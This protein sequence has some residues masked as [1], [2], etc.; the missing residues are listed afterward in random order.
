M[1]GVTAPE[2]YVLDPED[3]SKDLTFQQELYVL[4]YM[5]NGGKGGKAAEAAGYGSPA[6]A[7]S[8]LLSYPKIKAAIQFKKAER[9]KQYHLGQDAIL[10]ELAAVAGFNLGDIMTFDAAGNPGIDLAKATREQTKALASIET[11]RVGNG[12]GVI[13]TK[14]KVKT[15]DKLAALRLLMDHLGMLRTNTVAVQ[16][17]LDFGERMAAANARAL[18]GQSRPK[19]D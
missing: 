1:G 2:A 19:E 13:G 14:V 18:E 9:D 12:R 10:R 4:E 15:L 16:V 17:N 3:W 6:V 11:E 8:T 7:S 5:A